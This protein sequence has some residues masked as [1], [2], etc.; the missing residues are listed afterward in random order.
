MTDK[1]R[2][3][4]LVEKPIPISNGFMAT[5]PVPSVTEFEDTGPP[6]FLDAD[7]RKP[8]PLVDDQ[9]V[10]FEST[11]GTVVLLGCAHAGV[12]NTLRYVRELTGERPIHAVLGGMHLVGASA[13]RLKCTIDELRAMKIHCLA[14]AHCTGRAATAAL[15]DALPDRCIPCHVGTQVEF[16]LRATEVEV[17]L[18]LPANASSAGAATIACSSGCRCGR[19]P[20]RTKRLP[21]TTQ[22]DAEKAATIAAQRVPRGEPGRQ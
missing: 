8:D 3:T 5:G 13:Q 11:R 4:V 14:P 1:V 17:G 18:A 22:S 19:D 7:G 10:F 20:L 16:E 6:F 9:A 2:I 15:W 21:T 12:I